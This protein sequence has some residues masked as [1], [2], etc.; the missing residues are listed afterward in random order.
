MYKLFLAL[1]LYKDRWQTGF[2]PQAVA[3]RPGSRAQALHHDTVAVKRLFP[4]TGRLRPN[5]GGRGQSL[6]TREPFAPKSSF[7]ALPY[8]PCEPTSGTGQ[9]VAI[10]TRG[11]RRVN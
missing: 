10:R 1:R 5:R 6:L 4:Q 9:C 2:G 3:R 11:L 7:I 8:H